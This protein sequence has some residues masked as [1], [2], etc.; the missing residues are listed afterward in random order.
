MKQGGAVA[1]AGGH[2]PAYENVVI[3]GRNTAI[4]LAFDGRQN[5]VEEGHAVLAKGP[6]DTLETVQPSTR[7]ALRKRLLLFVYNVYSKELSF[8]K[9][10]DDG[11]RMAEADG[12]ERGI[13]RD[14]GE[15]ADGE[16]VRLPLGVED[17][18]NGHAG[19]EASA[20]GAEFL[21]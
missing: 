21:A 3:A 4:H 8:A 9:E 5:A 12:D 10:A 14:G 11:D 20:G 6:A 18:G 15:G 7:E 13:E 1:D 2:H 19:R 17:G 16:A